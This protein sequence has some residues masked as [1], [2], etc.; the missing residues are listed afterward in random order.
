MGIEC[1]LCSTPIQRKQLQISCSGCNN[2]FHSG[3]IY[4]GATDLTRILEDVP[5]LSW[6]CSG[7]ANNFI[8]VNDQ[9]ITVLIENKISNAISPILSEFNNIK[10]AYEKML[11]ENKSTVGSTT[12][13]KYSDVLKNKAS[14]AVIIQPKDEQESEKTKEDIMKTIDPIDDNLQF[15]KIKNIKNGGLLIGCRNKEENSKLLNLVQ[16]RLPDSY[17]IREV[18][19]IQPRIRIVGITS[20]FTEKQLVRCLPKMNPDLFHSPTECEVIKV[21]ITSEEK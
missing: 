7:C 4:N 5:G 21:S 15:S 11:N 17:E 12:L 20:S 18:S 19:G 16:E 13:I 8:T 6:K 14:P 10:S 1:N 2:V 3:C 9:E